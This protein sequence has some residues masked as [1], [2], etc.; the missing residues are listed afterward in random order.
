MWPIYLFL[1][2][3]FF[4]QCRYF[5]IPFFILLHIHFL[6]ILRPTI[7]H[8][9]DYMSSNLTQQFLH[10]RMNKEKVEG[11]RWLRRIGVIDL[12][13]F[14]IRKVR[15]RFEGTFVFLFIGSQLFFLSNISKFFSNSTSF[16]NHV[17]PSFFFF[18]LHDFHSLWTHRTSYSFLKTWLT[19]WAF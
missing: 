2:A 5:V 11:K 4:G 17:F 8:R 12:P 19:T 18:F 16:W 9:I 15:A 3:I 13:I 7:Y 6:Q 14:C 10:T 1:L